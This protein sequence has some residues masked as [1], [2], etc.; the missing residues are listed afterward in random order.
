MGGDNGSQKPAK[1]AFGC[2]AYG[3]IWAPAVSSWLAM[4]AY[5]SRQMEV[6]QIGQIAGA[7]VTDKMYT[8]SAENAL[9]KDFIAIEDATHIFLAEM[10]MILPKETILTLLEADKP[11]IS[12][13]Y[14]LRN[15]NGQ[16]CLYQKTVTPADN[17]YPHTP[18]SLFP[19]DA[20]FRVDCPGLGC[21]LMKR[22]VFSKIKQPYF[23]LKEYT[24][25][26]DMYF[27]TNAKTAGVEVWAHPKVMC[28]QIDYTV[29]GPEDYYRKLVED[30][31]F[32]ST[33]FI[34]GKDHVALKQT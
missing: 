19:T 22:E 16:P 6:Q 32:G 25:G 8:H 13:V 23:D 27:Y 2:T 31:K 29:V 10:D 34:I 18:V 28:Y 30:P 33:G 21:V 9:I 17:P 3:P 4:L 11:I 26:S 1:V 12:G 24:Y 20:P 5:T 14:F 15:G 7:G